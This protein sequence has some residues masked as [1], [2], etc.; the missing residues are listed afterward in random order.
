MFYITNNI[1][2]IIGMDFDIYP[3]LHVISNRSVLADLACEKHP[4]RITLNNDDFLSTLDLLKKFSKR[5]SL[6]GNPQIIVFKN[7]THIQ[8]Y[9]DKMGWGI[10]NSDSD[11]AQKIENKISQYEWIS[12]LEFHGFSVPKTKIGE[13]RSFDYGQLESD[14]GSPF[15]LQYNT[16]HTGSGTKLISHSHEWVN[17]VEKFPNREGKIAEHVRGKVYTVNA[18][19]MRDDV[20]CGETSL[21]LTGINNLTDNPL[22]TVGNDWCAVD[23]NTNNNVKKTAKDIG[24]KMGEIGWK[25]LFGIDVVIEEGT[26]KIFLIEINARQPASASFEN[27]IANLQGLKGPLDWNMDAF[28]SADRQNKIPNLS[29]GKYEVRASQVFLRKRSGLFYEK[30]GHI[31]DVGEYDENRNLLEKK[32]FF[33]ISGNTEKNT[34]VIPNATASEVLRVQALRSIAL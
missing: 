7:T 3:D 14:L 21:Q 34:F 32:A 19:V 26:G 17:E 29:I 13:L 27:R 6:R 15:I 9:C 11:I 33:D 23:E 28:M 25:G 12:E 20:L 10:L 30:Y 8:R 22:A 31:K 1:E 16:G 24:E 2:R 4:N 5:I 18:C